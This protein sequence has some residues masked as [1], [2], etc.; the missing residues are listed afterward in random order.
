MFIISFIYMF[1]ATMC[2]S[3]GEI[4][5]SMRHLVFLTLEWIPLCIPDSHP[6]RVTNTKCR[7]DKVISPDD[8]HMVARNVY[9]KE[10]DT[11]RK[12]VHQ[13]GFIYKIIQGCRSTKHKKYEKICYNNQQRTTRVISRNVP[14]SSTSHYIRRLSV[15]SARFML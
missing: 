15:T 10:I 4:T 5:L 8:G 9:R 3:S 7:I 11:L 1:R 12:I 6:H 13:V 2:P 14:F